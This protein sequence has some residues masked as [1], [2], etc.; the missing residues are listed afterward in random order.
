MKK[1]VLDAEFPTLNPSIIKDT[2]GDTILKNTK[3]GDLVTVATMAKFLKTQPQTVD[4]VMKSLMSGGYFESLGFKNIPHSSG[5]RVR[6]LVY[7]R[8]NKTS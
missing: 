8:T 2:H 5:R 4:Y 1:I 3:E 6:S 7:R